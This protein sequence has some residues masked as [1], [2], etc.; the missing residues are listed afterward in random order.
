MSFEG[1]DVSVLS[2]YVSII[3]FDHCF[4]NQEPLKGAGASEQPRQHWHLLIIT[5]SLNQWAGSGSF[6]ESAF[7]LV[8]PFC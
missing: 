5:G 4:L 3:A 6:M 2:L 8:V 7:H 1:S